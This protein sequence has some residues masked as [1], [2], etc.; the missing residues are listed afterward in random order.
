M[1]AGAAGILTE[2]FRGLLQPLK[3]TTAA[4]IPHPNS[5]F[6]NH[7]LIRRYRHSQRRPV[8]RK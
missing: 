6:I 2:V 3:N 5:L 8:N 4:S 7:F 1:P